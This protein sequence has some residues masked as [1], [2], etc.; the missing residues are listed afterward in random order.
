MKKSVTETERSCW[1][2]EGTSNK[3]VDT[4][5]SSS[6]S[7]VSGSIDEEEEELEDFFLEEEF[8]S[9]N[10]GDLNKTPVTVDQPSTVKGLNERVGW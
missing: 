4:T 3:T 10:I 5:T 1:P 6:S 2:D 9:V 8:D 7:G